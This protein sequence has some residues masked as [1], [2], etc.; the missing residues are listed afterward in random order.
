[1]LEVSYNNLDFLSIGDIPSFKTY[2]PLCALLSFLDGKCD[3]D[4]DTVECNFDG[5]DCKKR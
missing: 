4:A 1:M 3:E 2:L 5:G